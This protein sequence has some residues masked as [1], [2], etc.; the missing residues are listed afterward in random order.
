MKNI[1]IDHLQDVLVTVATDI[2]LKIL[3]AIALWLVGR[4][5]IGITLR[6]IRIEAV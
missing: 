4:W 1:D 2:G 6:L 5:L 3:A